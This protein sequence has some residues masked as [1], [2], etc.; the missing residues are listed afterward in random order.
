[1]PTICSCY[2]SKVNNSTSLT[3][4]LVFLG[5][6]VNLPVAFLTARTERDYDSPASYVLYLCQRYRKVQ[7]VVQQNQAIR[8]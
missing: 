7:S 1:L 3:P 2:N 5:R 8:I 6:E 4:N